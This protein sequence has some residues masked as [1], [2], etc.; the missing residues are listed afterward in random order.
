MSGC[1]WDQNMA[2]KVCIHTQGQKLRYGL[3]ELCIYRIL[4]YRYYLMFTDIAVSLYHQTQMEMTRNY[5]CNSLGARNRL[6]DCI[7]VRIVISS[8]SCP[9]FSWA[10]LNCLELSWVTSMRWLSHRPWAVLGC[11]QHT[12]A[13]L[14]CPKLSSAVMSYH[15]LSWAVLNCLG[16]SWAGLSCFELS[17]IVLS[18]PE[19]SRA[20]LICL[21][22]L[23][24]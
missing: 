2:N 17:S 22:I 23:E 15:G 8:M 4:Y 13:V 24:Q 10:L 1:T 11:L 9:E 12:W 6:Q 7:Y 5:A 19:L 20:V 3:T 16:M 14:S 21:K 18:Y